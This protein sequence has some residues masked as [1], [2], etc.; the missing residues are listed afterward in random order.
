MRHHDGVRIAWD[1]CR[2]PCRGTVAVV[3]CWT[4]EILVWSGLDRNDRRKPRRSPSRPHR[5]GHAGSWAVPGQGGASVGAA[6]AGAGVHGD[7]AGPVPGGFL[8]RAL[9]VAAADRAG[10]RALRVLPAR[11]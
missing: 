7:R 11:D 8:A 5:R 1:T 3:S 9:A 2:A 4:I 10:R 6:V